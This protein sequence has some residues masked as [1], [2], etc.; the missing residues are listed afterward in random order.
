MQFTREIDRLRPI[1]I[2]QELDIYRRALV[3]GDANLGLFGLKLELGEGGPPLWIPA[4]K[5]RQM[6][7]LDKRR[8]EKFIYDSPV[9]QLST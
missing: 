5:V 8:N 6:P 7:V 4:P 3:I 1:I 2:A 9:D